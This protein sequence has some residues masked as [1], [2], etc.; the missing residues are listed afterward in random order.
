MSRVPASA[1]SGLL[2]LLLL[3]ATAFSASHTLHQLLHQD[4]VGSSHLCLA[5]SFAKGQLSAAAVAVISAVMAFC[6]LWGVGLV[7]TSPFPGFDYR[8]SPSR[9]PPRF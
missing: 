6:C 1:L 5:C 3:V 9:A 4:G 8:T 2:A 7:S